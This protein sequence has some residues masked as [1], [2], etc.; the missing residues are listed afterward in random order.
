MENKII[1]KN[2]NNQYSEITV[3]K[4]CKCAEGVTSFAIKKEFYFAKICN[5]CQGLG[6]IIEKHIVSNN[7]WLD[8]N[9]WIDKFKKEK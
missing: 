1:V 5:K 8:L 2:I 7:G 3:E 4:D 9:Y 6:K